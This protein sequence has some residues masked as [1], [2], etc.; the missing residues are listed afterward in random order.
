MKRKIIV[1][2]LTA[3]AVC[4]CVKRGDIRVSGL[5]QVRMRGVTGSR[6]GIELGLRVSNASGSKVVLNAADFTVLKNGRELFRVT[7]GQRVV[8]ARRSDGTVVL[9]LTLRFGGVL[10][11]VGTVAALSGGTDG[12]AVSGRAT[13]RTGWIKK[14]VVLE[15]EPADRLLRQAGI[16]MDDVL[17]EL[18]R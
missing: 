17:K 13:L 14:T 2:L 18:G 1:M 5:E 8:L 16:D 6:A 15:N 4:S 9:P 7:L 3:L 10:G 11:A 12:L